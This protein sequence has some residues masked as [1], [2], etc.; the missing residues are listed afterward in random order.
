VV[1][2]CKVFIRLALVGATSV[3]FSK[4]VMVLVRLGGFFGCFYYSSGVRF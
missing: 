4:S 1:G 3:G 2:G